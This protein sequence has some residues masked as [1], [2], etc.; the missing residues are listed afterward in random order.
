MAPRDNTEAEA[1]ANEVRGAFGLRIRHLRTQQGISQ[2]NLAHLADMDRTYVGGI[3]RGILNPSLRNIA[4]L[5]W[6]LGVEVERLFSDLDVPM[7]RKP[8]PKGS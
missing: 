1:F 4:K 2:E 3:E 6:T 8:G 7:H 5:A